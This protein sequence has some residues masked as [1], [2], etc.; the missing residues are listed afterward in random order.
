[1]VLGTHGQ[2][3]YSNRMGTGM[4]RVLL[5]GTAATMLLGQVSF[6]ASLGAAQETVAQE[7]EDGNA[8]TFAVATATSYTPIPNGSTLDIIAA[9][10][11]ELANDATNLTSGTLAT[12][13]YGV[14]RDA[15]YV[16]DVAA[17]LVRGVDQDAARV[18]PIQGTTR[19]DQYSNAEQ[20]QSDQPLTQGNL[21]SSNQGALLNPREQQRGGHLLRVSLSVY[22]RKSGLYVWRGQIERD[23]AEVDAQSSLAQMVPAL[24]NHFGQGLPPTEVPLNK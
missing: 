4:K 19:G 13:G 18:S 3:T 12:R 9:A 22:D 20:S 5:V 6:G 14:S 17:V 8:A 7:L 21:F 23:S 10:D 2:S 24:L 11:T 16:V 1:M 15:D